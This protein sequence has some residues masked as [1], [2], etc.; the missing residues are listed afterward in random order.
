MPIIVRL[1]K[2]KIV[3]MNLSKGNQ[4]FQDLLKKNLSLVVN[5]LNEGNFDEL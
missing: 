2:D 3:G 5:D 4:A 1:K